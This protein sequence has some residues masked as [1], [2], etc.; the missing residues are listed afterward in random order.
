M[1]TYLEE[2]NHA[3]AQVEL[4]SYEGEDFYII[5]CRD[6]IIKQKEEGENK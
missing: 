2:V 3:T 1:K 5:D 4:T 6:D